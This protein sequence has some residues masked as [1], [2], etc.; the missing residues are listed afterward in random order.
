MHA[1]TW[2]SVNQND[3]NHEGMIEGI[4]QQFVMQHYITSL[5]P[6]FIMLAM[7]TSIT[8]LTSWLKINIYLF[9]KTS[10]FIKAF[11]PCCK[12]LITIAVKHV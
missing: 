7:H 4:M 3:Y 9:I 12:V 1:V 5:D 2:F 11:I 6:F 8:R 10:L